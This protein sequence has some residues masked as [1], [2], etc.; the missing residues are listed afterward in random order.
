MARVRRV[1]AERH[2]PC[3]WQRRLSHGAALRHR[4][5]ELCASLGKIIADRQSGASERSP[6][7]GGGAKEKQAEKRLASQSPPD[8]RGP[9]ARGKGSGGRANSAKAF[10]ASN[11]S[12]PKP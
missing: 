1:Q 4:A 10:N 8:K 7:E 5:P 12:P 2:L 6:G 3:L 9:K 11:P